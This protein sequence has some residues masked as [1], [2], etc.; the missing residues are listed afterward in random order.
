[1]FVE[2]AKGL[3]IRS[4]LHTDYGSTCA[5]LASFGLEGH[6]SRS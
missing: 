3:G 2:I 5:K 6:E 4:V 1:M